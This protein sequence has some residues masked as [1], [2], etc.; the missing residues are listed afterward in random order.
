MLATLIIASSFNAAILSRL[1]VGYERR[2]IQTFQDIFDND[3]LT[4]RVVT[5][6]ALIES[7]ESGQSLVFQEMRRMKKSGRIKT[8][9]TEFLYTE[10]F[11][12]GVARG[13]DVA[14]DDS[15]YLNKVMETDYL[16]HKK[17]RFYTTN[18]PIT[19]YPEAL[20]LPKGSPLTPAFNA[21][22]EI[23]M[24]K[25]VYPYH[26]ALTFPTF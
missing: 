2:S 8:N 15:V 14:V 10:E 23:V 17:C 11:L 16:R 18:A 22:F 5:S 4:L 26:V 12:D 25:V 7:I 9:K 19:I 6:Y 21:R 24:K 20:V 3:H 13:S 1:T